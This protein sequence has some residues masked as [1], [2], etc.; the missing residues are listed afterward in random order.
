MSR[1][2][3]YRV[4]FI[5]ED[6]DAPAWNWEASTLADALVRVQQVMTTWTGYYTGDVT[7]YTATHYRTVLHFDTF[8]TDQYTE[9][10]RWRRERYLG[11]GEL[12]PEG[13]AAVAP[14]LVQQP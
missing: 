7:E 9:D 8:P 5:C 3:C 13:R 14:K 12:S 2:A 11:Y 10:D 6:G 4:S 1:L